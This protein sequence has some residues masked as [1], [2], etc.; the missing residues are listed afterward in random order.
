MLRQV[1]DV[2]QHLPICSELTGTKTCSMDHPGGW[3]LT[4][5][6]EFR[7]HSPSFKHQPGVNSPD[8]S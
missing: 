2:G 5:H 3:P 1:D 4:R 7:T 8:L 6:L